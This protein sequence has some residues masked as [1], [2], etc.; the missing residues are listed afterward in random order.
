MAVEPA[1]WYAGLSPPAED[2]EGSDAAGRSPA[3]TFDRTKSGVLAGLLDAMEFEVK[4]MPA[5]EPWPA[6][7]TWRTKKQDAT[8]GEI[9]RRHAQPVIEPPYVQKAEGHASGDFHTVLILQDGSA[10]AFGSDDSGQCIVPVHRIPSGVRVVSCGA[11]A[12]HTV[13]VLDDGEALA[14]G[15]NEDGQCRIPPCPAGRRFMWCEAGDRHTILGLDDGTTIAFGDNA[16]GQCEAPFVPAGAS[17]VS[18]SA[19]KTHT[20]FLLDTGDAIAVGNNI[21]GQSFFPQKPP[22]TKYVKA[23]AGAE[24]TVLLRDDG[25]AAACGKNTH[26]QCVLEGLPEG[27]EVVA[28]AAGYHHSVL[29]LADGSAH[30]FGGNAFFGEEAEDEEFEDFALSTCCK[31]PILPDGVKCTSAVAGVAHTVLMLDDGK[32]LAFGSNQRGQC[33]MPTLASPCIPRSSGSG[34]T[35]IDGQTLVV[36]SGLLHGARNSQ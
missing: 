30:A 15:R 32:A 1:T 18:A 7:Q 2:E 17:I 28:I 11:G 27:A 24:H 31:V 22:G 9:R 33:S 13:L 21:Y 6:E 19:G 20:V 5:R 4:P 36:W 35:A 14:F 16:F 34:V 25:V 29:V 12:G 23:A 8:L 26:G 10:V 3:S